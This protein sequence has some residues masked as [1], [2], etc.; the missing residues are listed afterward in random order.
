MPVEWR[1][2]TPSWRVLAACRRHLRAAIA[3][4]GQASSESPESVAAQGRALVELRETER[5]QDAFIGLVVHEL[6]T[7]VTAIKGQ[8]QLLRS[9]A[10]RQGLDADQLAAGLARI[11][12][13]AD[14]LAATLDALVAET[15]EPGEPGPAAPATGPR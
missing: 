15:A 14:A 5:A 2:P 13:G 8:A 11:D 6:R 4:L 7:P 10:D 12:A 1:P 9:Q 3:I